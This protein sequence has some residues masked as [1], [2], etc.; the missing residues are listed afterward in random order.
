[1]SHTISLENATPFGNREFLYRFVQYPLRASFCTYTRSVK[2]LRE[3]N[4]AVQDLRQFLD[5]SITVYY[6]ILK[7]SEKLVVSV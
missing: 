6:E 7:T 5:S 4:I 3:K 1:M 2:I